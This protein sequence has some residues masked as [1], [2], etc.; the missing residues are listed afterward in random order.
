MTGLTIR[1][2]PVEQVRP[3]RHA[4][5]RAGRPYADSEYPQDA[6]A[7]HVAAVDGSGAVVGCATV[8]PEPY[9]D[10]PGAWRLRGMAVADGLRG[11]G[12][13]TLVLAEAEAAARSAGARLMWCNAR[14]TA[15]PFYAGRGWRGEGEEFLAEGLPHLRMTLQLG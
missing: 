9:G 11:T 15:V 1:R 7:V 13:G 2:V 4:V 14:M 10:D 5:L 6:T 3:L 12:V 8:F